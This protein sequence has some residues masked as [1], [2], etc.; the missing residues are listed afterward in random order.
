MFGIDRSHVAV[1]NWVPK[2]D[3]QPI[4]IVSEDQLVVD[5]KMIRLHDQK[6][7]LYGAVDPYTNEMG[8]ANRRKAFDFT[9]L[10]L[11]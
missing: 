11:A 10:R 5:E 8:L 9:V 2:S 4:S 3:L 1:H 6:F 7:W